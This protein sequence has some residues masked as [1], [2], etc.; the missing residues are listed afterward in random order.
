MYS[1]YGM[2]HK[3]VPVFP[4][5]LPCNG[6]FAFRVRFRSVFQFSVFLLLCQ[7]FKSTPQRMVKE[8]LKNG[9]KTVQKTVRKIITLQRTFKKQ[10][11]N[12][13]L[14]ESKHECTDWT[15]GI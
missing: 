6:N 9:V 2:G 1:K 13:K 12:V 8:P 5:T 3:K 4:N 15:D 10:C 11:N 7:R 14:Q